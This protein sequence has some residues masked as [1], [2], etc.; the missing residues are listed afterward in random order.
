ME[1][2]EAHKQNRL[3]I[4]KLFYRQQL[5]LYDHLFAIDQIV[6]NTDKCIDCFT[7]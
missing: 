1:T 4:T 7:D 5:V 3:K 6:K 2:L